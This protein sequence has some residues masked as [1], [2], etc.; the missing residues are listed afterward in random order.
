M[1]KALNLPEAYYYAD[2]QVCVVEDFVSGVPATWTGV[3]TSATAASATDKGGAVSIVTTTTDNNVSSLILT[4]KPIIPAVDEPIHFAARIRFAEAATN[5]AN[6]YV[7]LSSNAPATQ[8]QANGAGPAASYTGFGFF[9][10]D[11]NVNW[12]VEVSNA[13]VKSTQ[14]LNGQAVASLTRAAKVAGSASYQLLEIEIIAKTATKMDV[15]FKI[16]GVCV[17]KVT[18]FVFT[19]MVAVGPVFVCMTGSTTA[20]TLIVDL[21]KWAHVR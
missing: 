10:V 19:S 20:E 6:L 21:A 15:S 2:R 5:Q 17:F 11:G 14:E 9:K 3:G 18:D 1:P 13:A 12:K 8:M 7:G 4:A 16:D